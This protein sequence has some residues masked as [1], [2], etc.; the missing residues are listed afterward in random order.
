MVILTVSGLQ[1]YCGYLSDLLLVVGNNNQ[2]AE[3]R[4][5]SELQ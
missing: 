4:S 2:L 5:G 1:P 3:I